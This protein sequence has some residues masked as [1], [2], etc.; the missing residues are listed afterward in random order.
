[1]KN[2]TKKSEQL[3]KIE[4]TFDETSARRKSDIQKL[5][6]LGMSQEQVDRVNNKGRKYS[7]TRSERYV[8]FF[9]EI[10]I[11]TKKFDYIITGLIKTSK[12]STKGENDTVLDCVWVLYIYIQVQFQNQKIII[13]FQFF[14]CFPQVYH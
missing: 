6:E 2:I 3:G 5:E 4:T 14:C 11:V 1:M 7:A 9:F 13:I 8:I 10:T 12:I